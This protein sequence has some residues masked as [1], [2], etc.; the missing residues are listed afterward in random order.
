MQFNFAALL[1]DS[2]DNCG[3]SIQADIVF[4][5]D[6]SSSVKEH[7][8]REQLRFVSRI[9]Q[10]LDVD[11]GH[12]R[13]GLLS[14]HSYPRIHFHLRDYKTQSQV[15]EAIKSVWYRYG[16]TN[17][18]DAIRTVR[19]VMFTRSKGA[20]TVDG[21]PQVLVLITDGV[22]NMDANQTM[23]EAQVAH[24]AGIH[25]YTIGVGLVGFT[26]EIDQIA[27]PP[28]NFN[29]YVVKHSGE[30]KVIEEKFVR[31]MCL[32]RNLHTGCPVFAPASPACDT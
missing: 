28:S 9:V 12:A 23:P 11:G 4:A 13:V 17:T 27:S 31:Q 18:A 16:G 26:E 6:A 10:R 21:V 24:K 20:R 1:P 22:S 5:V 8:F 25:I 2:T 19:K 29:R 15:L 7:N 3:A 32:G 30:L 14:F